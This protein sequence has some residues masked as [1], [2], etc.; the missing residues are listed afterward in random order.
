MGN[1]D[2]NCIDGGWCMTGYW[3]DGDNIDLLFGQYDIESYIETN[4]VVPEELI[5]FNYCPICGR[6]LNSVNKERNEN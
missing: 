5:V 4:N 6:K 2:K 3:A 1:D